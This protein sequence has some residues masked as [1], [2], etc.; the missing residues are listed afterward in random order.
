MRSPCLVLGLLLALSGSL[1]GQGLF[2][3]ATQEKEG[4]IKGLDLGGFLRSTLYAGKAASPDAGQIKSGYGEFSLKAKTTVEGFGGAFAEVRFRDGMEFDERISQ[5]TLREAY[6]DAFAGR[7]DFRVGH[8]IVVWGRADGLNPTD[9]IT[10]RDMLVRSPDED[11]RRMANFLIRTYYNASPVRLEG[12]WIPFYRPSRIPTEFISFPANVIYGGQDYPAARLEDSAFAV[13]LNLELPSLDG[14]LSYFNGNNPFP[15]MS[16]E[17][18]TLSPPGIPVPIMNA[19]L[20]SYRMQ[21]LGADFATT[22]GGFGL[23]GEAAYRWPH[24]DYKASVYIINPDLY[25]VAGIDREFSGGLSMIFQYLGR[26][27]TDFEEL[28]PPADPR[29]LPL[30]RLEEKNRLLVSQQYEFS[31]A[32]T[33]RIA[34][35]LMYETLDLE[36]M[37]YFNVT[38]EEFLIKPKVTYRITDALKLIAGGECYQGPSETLFDLIDPYLSAFFGELRLSF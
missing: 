15:G 27:V 35:S 19:F 3:E 12:I 20:K 29:L 14:S 10:P 34:Q 6:V 13:K 5:F 38:T 21:V 8:Q 9:N 36:L 26:Y 18:L 33:L 17:L 31:H 24:E 22:L 37:G 23:R 32:L 11:D 4:V 7:F 1:V 25:F 28:Q 2:E 30:F 16:A